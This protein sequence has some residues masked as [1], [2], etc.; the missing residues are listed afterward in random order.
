MAMW[1]S[2]DGGIREPSYRSEACSRVESRPRAARIGGTF[3]TGSPEKL[4]PLTTR[5]PEHRARGSRTP[6]ITVLAVQGAAAET[7]HFVTGS[8]KGSLSTFAVR[9]GIFS[10]VALVEFAFQSCAPIAP[11]REA[12][13]SNSSGFTRNEFA[14]SL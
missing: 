10:G 14:P 13:F 6:E 11:N 3:G 4:S 9:E 7:S 1:R 5:E 2:T 8:E 12:I